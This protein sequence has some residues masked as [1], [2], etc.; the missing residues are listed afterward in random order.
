MRKS[1]GEHIRSTIVTLTGLKRLLSSY[2][3]MS[4]SLPTSKS[5]TSL[6]AINLVVVNWHGTLLC[7]GVRPHSVLAYEE[8]SDKFRKRV[9]EKS[10]Q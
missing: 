7:H 8:A 10:R 5:F 9:A 2:L 6:T 3:N 4:L 1:R